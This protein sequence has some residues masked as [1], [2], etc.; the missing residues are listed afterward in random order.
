[1]ARR[2]MR[3]QML[4]RNPTYLGGR[5]ACCIKR[6]RNF[7]HEFYPSMCDHCIAAR[8]RK[9]NQTRPPTPVPM[10]SREDIRELARDLDISI[11]S[12]I[13]VQTLNKPLAQPNPRIDALVKKMLN[14]GL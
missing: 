4:Y 10:M 12:D 5:C 2:N 7:N 13:D 9:D 6:Q 1:M 11:R 3:K 8:S 14:K